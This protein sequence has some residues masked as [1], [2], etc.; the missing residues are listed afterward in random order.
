MDEE[1]FL[2]GTEQMLPKQAGGGKVRIEEWEKG[3]CEQIEPPFV[4]F[5]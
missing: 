2:G 5:L 4:A 3:V 1:G